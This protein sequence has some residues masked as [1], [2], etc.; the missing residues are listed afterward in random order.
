MWFLSK[1]FIWISVAAA[2]ADF[3][4][5]TCFCL[6]KNCLVKFD[7]YI[8]SGSVTVIIP[9]APMLIIAKF[10]SSS[11]PIA[12]APITNVFIF[13]IFLLF[14]RPITILRLGK[15]SFYLIWRSTYW[16]EFYGRSWIISL[17]WNVKN[18]LIGVYL[19]VIAFIIYWETR[20]PKYAP[21]TGNSA[22]E[23]VEN[24]RPNFMRFCVYYYVF[25]AASA[26]FL[27]I[28]SNYSA[29]FNYQFFI[30]LLFFVMNS[31]WAW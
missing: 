10:L 17:K 19:L 20:P 29:S 14:Y 11:Q 25:L 26:I 28:S 13:S 12:P 24:F 1:G 9:S 7:V 16:A 6:N 5:F 2:V 8:W 4:F 30:F 21:K 22:S 23:I 15:L 31:S 18:C 3:G 27:S